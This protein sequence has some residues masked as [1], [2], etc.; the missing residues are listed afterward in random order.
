MPFDYLWQF[1]NYPITNQ[2]F[3]EGKIQ[4]NKTKLYFNYIDSINAHENQSYI[5]QLKSTAF[6]VEKNGVKNSLIFDK[7]QHLKLEIENDKIARENER[8]N[9]IINLYNA[10]VVD[11]NG[12]INSFNDFINYR[13]R[14]FKPQKS[15]AEIQ[16]M[17]DIPDKKF[18]D[19]RAKLEQISKPDVNTTSLMNQL[20]KSIEDASVQLRTQQDWLKLYLSKKKS[21]RK[22]MFYK[23]TWFGIPL[24]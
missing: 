8:Q 18:K 2:A 22:S 20:A 12:G 15:D 4:Q 14:Q 11:Y 19:A 5:D 13:N 16:S 3:Y 23:A 1:L 9:K 24:N 6:R 17:I 10:A 7:L 21:G